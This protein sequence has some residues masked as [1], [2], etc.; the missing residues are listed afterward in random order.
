M[1]AWLTAFSNGDL[2]KAMREK[3]A[4]F[5]VALSCLGSAL[6]QESSGVGESVFP[7]DSVGSTADDSS[8]RRARM[9]VAVV[10]QLDCQ[11]LKALI[12]VENT[13]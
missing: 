4:S 12:K 8:S 9:A 1:K 11:S 3:S 13:S 2:T 6:F 7:E 5:D 10:N